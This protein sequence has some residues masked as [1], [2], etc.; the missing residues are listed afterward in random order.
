L[1]FIY[2]P[3]R[4]NVT[5]RLARRASLRRVWQESMGLLMAVEIAKDAAG[6]GGVSFLQI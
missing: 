2:N 4:K 3:F 6:A 5:Q 1:F